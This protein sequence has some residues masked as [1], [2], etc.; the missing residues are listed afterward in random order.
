VQFGLLSCLSG[1]ILSLCLPPVCLAVGIHL[2]DLCDPVLL[3]W[4]VLAA[5]LFEIVVSLAGRDCYRHLPCLSWSC[6]HHTV[7][8]A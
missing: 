6:V 1:R 2:C 7:H 5:A 8:K 4:L 3:V